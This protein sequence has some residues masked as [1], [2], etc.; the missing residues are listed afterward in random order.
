MNFKGIKLKKI[1][2]NS[3]GHVMHDSIYIIV[4]K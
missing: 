4:L 2:S 3:K 1:K